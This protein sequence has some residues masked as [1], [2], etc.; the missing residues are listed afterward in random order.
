MHI[1][2]RDTTLCMYDYAKEILLSNEIE[3]VR[4]FTHEELKE[5]II[6]EYPEISKES[7]ERMNRYQLIQFLVDQFK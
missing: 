2:S 1:E 3:K 7:I 6:K 4:R 5:Y